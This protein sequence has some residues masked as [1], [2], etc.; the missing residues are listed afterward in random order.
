MRTIKIITSLSAAILLALSC[1]TETT[2]SLSTKNVY[3]EVGESVALTASASSG[4]AVSFKSQNPEVASVSEEGEVKAVG[5]GRT[6]IVAYTADGQARCSVYIAPKGAADLGIDLT[7]DGKQYILYWAKKN[8]GAASP[9]AA[10]NYYAW[11][12]TSTKA[13]YNW[14][15]YSLYSG[16]AEQKAGE[17]VFDGSFFRYK[18]GSSYGT[19]DNKTELEAADD[20]A[21]KALGGAWRIPTEEEWKELGKQ[22]K[23]DWDEALKC[24]RVTGPNGNSIV[25]PPAGYK[26]MDGSGAKNVGS[27][28]Y[29]W[30]A[31]L[32][33][34]NPVNAIMFFFNSTSTSFSHASSFRSDGNTVRA[35]TE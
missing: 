32:D 3:L 12:E 4:E 2:V 15:T 21:R 28:G 5:K 35:V 34:A 10:G 8:V 7:R 16:T 26:G 22:C 19:A 25:L 23:L 27:Y 6:T 17:W 9:E 30:S 18:T 13:H 11:G 33:S 31:T 1:K 20:A 29:Y 24:L 14:A